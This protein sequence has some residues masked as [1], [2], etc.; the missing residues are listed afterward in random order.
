[1]A[2]TREEIKRLKALEEDFGLSNTLEKHVGVRY[3]DYIKPSNYGSNTVNLNNRDPKYDHYLPNLKDPSNLHYLRSFIDNPVYKERFGFRDENFPITDNSPQALAVSDINSIIAHGSHLLG[4][5]C[6]SGHFDTGRPGGS[7]S[8]LNAFVYTNEMKR[9][10]STYFKPARRELSDGYFFPVW[11]DC[12]LREG[13]IYYKRT[14]DDTSGRVTII[15]YTKTSDG[16]NQSD[17]FV[18]SPPLNNFTKLEN[19]GEFKVGGGYFGKSPFDYKAYLI[20]DVGDFLNDS[21]NLTVSAHANRKTLVSELN[22]IVGP[23]LIENRRE[24]AFYR[25]PNVYGLNNGINIET[26]TE[27]L[28]N[29]WMGRIEE[30]I[31]LR[32]KF[33]ET[34]VP[35]GSFKNEFIKNLNY[36]LNNLRGLIRVVKKHNFIAHSNFTNRESNDLTNDRPA[37]EFLR[38]YVYVVHGVEIPD[39]EMYN[40]IHT[41]RIEIDKIGGGTSPRQDLDPEDYEGAEYNSRKVIF[42]L[43][44]NLLGEVSRDLEFP[45]PDTK[46]IALPPTQEEYD[47]LPS[48]SVT[49]AY[50]PRY[51]YAKLKG[52]EAT[53]ES[54]ILAF[55]EMII[56]PMNNLRL[57]NKNHPARQPYHEFLSDKLFVN[58][59]GVLYTQDDIR[60]NR[61][62]SRRKIASNDPLLFLGNPMTSEVLNDVYLYHKD[63]YLA[64]QL[65]DNKNFVK[66]VYDTIRKLTL[67]K[68]D[69]SIS[70]KNTLNALGIIAES[71][72]C[73]GTLEI[74]YTDKDPTSNIFTPFAFNNPYHDFNDSQLLIKL[75]NL[76]SPPVFSSPEL[77]KTEELRPYYYFA[78]LDPRYAL[79]DVMM[80]YKD[81]WLGQ[82]LSERKVNELFSKVAND[83][84]NNALRVRRMFVHVRDAQRG[85][86]E[87]AQWEH[88][89][90]RVGYVRGFDQIQMWGSSCKSVKADFNMI[91]RP[92][93]HIDLRVRYEWT[94][95]AGRG[96]H[97]K[98]TAVNK[99]TLAEDLRDENNNLI[100]FDNPLVYWNGQYDHNTIRDS[101]LLKLKRSIPTTHMIKLYIYKQGDDS[102]DAINI[103]YIAFKGLSFAN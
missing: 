87:N 10:V 98:F 83:L 103:D 93:T 35:T 41:T 9:S 50:F 72:S 4:G 64:A 16:F 75:R 84:M 13:R 78:I 63:E 79:E 88:N 95:A 43:K 15:N 100:N 77:T 26:Y 21:T 102:G 60:Y 59:D 71:L 55:K 17:N 42:Q 96:I 54:L 46:P 51:K 57:R 53:P 97:F 68:M 23:I 2:I 48:D 14:R 39:Y 33:V 82:N 73:I 61:L 5:F 66:Y 7:S 12:Y 45:Y 3:E 20:K 37:T 76:Q 74:F 6:A 44:N 49:K 99:A 85:Y 86:L 19:I 81:L 69:N 22:E 92:I 52:R 91:T 90:G 70:V 29:K 32:I 36:I 34:F 30:L 89:W 101:G 18:Y 1:M 24:N 27:T 25:F 11:V 56:D 28:K 40:K 47:A 8:R 62:E 80:K 58:Y 38:Y 67:G 65:P 94:N 31:R